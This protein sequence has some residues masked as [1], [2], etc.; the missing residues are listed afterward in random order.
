MNAGLGNRRITRRFGFNLN[1]RWQES[2]IWESTFGVGEIPAFATMDAQVSFSF[3]EI[4]STFK[5]GGSNML[6]DYYT[7]SYGSAQVGG[8]YYFTWTF[9]EIMN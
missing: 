9:D 3:P 2:F 8:M 4:N 5:V 7:T 6:N 1:Y